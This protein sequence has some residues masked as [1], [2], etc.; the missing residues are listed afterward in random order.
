M[1]ET[2]LTLQDMPTQMLEKKTLKE[3]EAMV[4]VQLAGSIICLEQ[5]LAAA[6]KKIAEL[7]EEKKPLNL[8]EVTKNMVMQSDKTVTIFYTGL[9]STAMFN[10]LLQLVLSIQNPTYRTCLDPEQQLIL[11]LMRLRLGLLT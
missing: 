5:D 7:E 10:A 2:T 9:V 8:S 1:T 11:V 4:R 6:K 3:N